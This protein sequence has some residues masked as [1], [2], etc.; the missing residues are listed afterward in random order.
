MA[1][2]SLNRTQIGFDLHASECLSYNLFTSMFLTSEFLLLVLVRRD[3]EFGLRRSFRFRPS[4]LGL[5]GEAKG[6]DGYAS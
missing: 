3:S 4:D 5:W 2:S 1:S 6:F